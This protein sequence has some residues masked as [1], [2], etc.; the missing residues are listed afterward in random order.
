[1]SKSNF[2]IMDEM[3]APDIRVHLR[4]DMTIRA[5][6]ALT[7]AGREYLNANNV[8][9]T[10]YDDIQNSGI[11]WEVMLDVPESVDLIASGYE[12]I[13]P[14]CESFNHEI[15]ITESVTCPACT[16]KYQVQDYNHAHN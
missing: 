7:D 3:T 2:E 10:S 11:C 4:D 16:A 12:W 13:C 5:A 9:G 8:V 6:I 1:M 14:A 15:E